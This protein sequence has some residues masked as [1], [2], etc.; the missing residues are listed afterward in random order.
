MNYS[1]DMDS[2]SR[3]QRQISIQH[4]NNRQQA[5]GMI[6]LLYQSCAIK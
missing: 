1:D 4:N 6:F 3:F 5:T 2:L